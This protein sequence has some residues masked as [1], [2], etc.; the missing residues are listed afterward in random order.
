MFDDENGDEP[1]LAIALLTIARLIIGMYTALQRGVNLVQRVGTRHTF[2]SRRGPLGGFLSSSVILPRPLL[3]W[4][5]TYTATVPVI[6]SDNC[7]D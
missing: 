5:A 7:I 1:F 6:K 3:R 2:L 4:F